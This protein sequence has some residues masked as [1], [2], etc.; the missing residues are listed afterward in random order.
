[1]ASL[2]VGPSLQALPNRIGIGRA[3]PAPRPSIS[4]AHAAKAATT[5]S[6][7]SLV[8]SDKPLISGGGISCNVQLTEPNVYLTG[9]D[10]EGRPSDHASTAAL[11][12]GRLIVNVQKAAK[13]KSI[14]L[15]FF[16]K[17]RTEWPEGE[18]RCPT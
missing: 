16:G 8:S 6:L 10:P 17:A 2:V 5:V 4:T 11:I 9:F 18:T 15:R 7:K 1:M 12:R 3:S 14:T 13:I